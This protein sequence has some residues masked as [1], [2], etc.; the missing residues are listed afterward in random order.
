MFLFLPRSAWPAGFNLSVLPTD[1]PTNDWNS[2]ELAS[3]ANMLTS[4]KKEKKS[5][6]QKRRQP[7]KE[8]NLNKEDDLKN[9]NDL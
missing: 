7:Q 1:R 9:E 2:L 4:T 8:D 6:P 3:L 5:Q